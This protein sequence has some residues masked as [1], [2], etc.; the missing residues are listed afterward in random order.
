MFSLKNLTGNP[1]A[2]V[3]RETKPLVAQINALEERFKALS[4]EEL[5]GQTAIFRERLEK[6]ESLADL[7]PEAFAAVREAAWRTM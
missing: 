1:G 5:K 7:L 4:S 2:K 6:G 3:T